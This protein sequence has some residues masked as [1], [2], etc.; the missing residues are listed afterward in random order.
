VGDFDGDEKSD[1]LIVD[2]ISGDWQVALNSG[3]QFIPLK[4][5]FKPW[6]AS[7]YLQ[8]LVGIFSEDKRASLCARNVQNGIIDFAISAIG[9][10]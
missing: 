2:L 6:A 8:P 5:P 9:K 4:E 1:I 3:N 10:K 7:P